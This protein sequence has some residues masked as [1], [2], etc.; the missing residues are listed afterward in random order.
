MTAMR[1]LK[2]LREKRWCSTEMNFFTACTWALTP[3]AMR[4]SVDTQYDHWLK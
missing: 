4:I 1:E 3:P 2:L